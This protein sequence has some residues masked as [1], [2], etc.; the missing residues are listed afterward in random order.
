M[1]HANSVFIS[2]AVQK[3]ATA[4]GAT[5]INQIIRALKNDCRQLVAGQKEPPVHLHLQPIKQ[6]QK[7]MEI[8]QVKLAIDGRVFPSDDGRFVIEVNA[9]SDPGRQNFTLA[10]EIGHTFFLLHEPKERN[11]RTDKSIEVY[12][13]GNLEERLCDI[14]AAELLMPEAMF[15]HKAFDLGPSITAIRKLCQLFRCSTMAV[16]RRFAEAGAWKTSISYWRLN[17]QDSSSFVV[18]WS[19]TSRSVGLYL[20]KGATVKGI[21]LLEDTWS[22]GTLEQGYTDFGFSGPRAN[23]VKSEYFTQALAYGSGR[24]KRIVTMTIFE[25]HPEQLANKYKIDRRTESYYEDRRFSQLDLPF[26][27]GNGQPPLE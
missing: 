21:S 10:H 16:S 20:P 3:Y 15:V 22:K 4:H 11:R 1:R 23:R 5:D 17:E 27:F 6:Q 24:S 9:Q 14:A 18:E 12:D 19:Q 25:P 2:G 26:D 8:R 13:V 7:I